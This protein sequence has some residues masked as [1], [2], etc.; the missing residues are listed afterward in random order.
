MC[1]GVR[2]SLLGCALLA[3]SA[4][5][6]SQDEPLSN[7]ETVHTSNAA[8]LNRLG[9]APLQVPDGHHKKRL[10]GPEPPGLNSQTRIHL[11]YSRRHGHRDSHVYIVKLP[12]SPP[13]YTI[14]KPHKSGKDEKLSK[15]GGSFPVG[16]Q[17]NGK[18]GKIFHWNLPVMKKITEK[19]RLQTQQRLEQAR[20]K[21]EESKKKVQ[22][23]RHSPRPG[24]EEDQQQ[25]QQQQKGSKHARN[26]DKRLSYA[27]G[28]ERRAQEAAK[29]GAGNKTYRLDD[30][31]VHRIHLTNELHGSRSSA[32]GGKVKKHRKKAAMSYYAPILTKSGPTSIH[33]N[34]PGNGKPKA[35]YVIEKNRKPVYYHKLLP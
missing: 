34:F 10:A 3:L 22:P 27:K 14:T 15:S 35:F 29:K 8:I 12:A 4:S 6:I 25:Q 31:S 5:A 2:L 32:G 18:P 9:L 11:P 30:S 23:P 17:G 1:R 28:E 20:K 26:N 16:F 19:K 21:L 13:Y 7:F 33:K 24:H